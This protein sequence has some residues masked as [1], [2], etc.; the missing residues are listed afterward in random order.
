M[1]KIG[2][3]I[4]YFF[5]FILMSI[6]VYFIQQGLLI[7]LL[8][9]MF[10]DIIGLFSGEHIPD[11][12]LVHLPIEF[13]VISTFI[14]GL[15]AFIFGWIDRL[16]WIGAILIILLVGFNLTLAFFYMGMTPFDIGLLLL[17]FVVIT[18]T[19]PL[20]II[21]IH[22]K[23]EPLV[24][25]ATTSEA[26][27]RGSDLSEI[28]HLKITKDV[29]S[30][31]LKP[32]LI[33][34][35]AVAFV[36][37]VIASV[38]SEFVQRLLHKP[39]VTI[40]I[41]DNLRQKEFVNIRVKIVEEDDSHYL[42]NL[43]RMRIGNATGTLLYSKDEYL[44]SEVA[45]SDHYLIEL[46]LP[47]DDVKKIIN[48]R[49]PKETNTTQLELN[50][51]GNYKKDFIFNWPK[52]ELLNQIKI[53]KF[54]VQEKPF[55]KERRVLVDSDTNFKEGSFRLEKSTYFKKGYKLRN[56]NIDFR[57]EMDAFKIDSYFASESHV[58]YKTYYKNSIWFSEEDIK[59]SE[60]LTNFEKGILTLEADTYYG[61]DEL[62]HY[63]IEILDV[64]KKRLGKVS[65]NIRAVDGHINRHID[66]NN[67]AKKR[68][69]SMRDVDSYLYRIDTLSN[70]KKEEEK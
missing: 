11:D 19:L 25:N 49:L 17:A 29:A 55:K 43:H 4:P 44:F 24:A 58:V 66:I 6:F 50:N 47:D 28:K 56:I 45:R 26:Q 22:F 41:E 7:V 13:I 5:S 40:T 16:R 57:G 59:S 32:L 31:S 46:I 37:A 36:I 69:F 27:E 21:F 1:A 12:S 48:I 20:R 14:A 60:V 65:G 3:K 67:L 62:L 30:R 64:K 34:F 15:L 63:Y 54:M 18:V 2:E 53:E 10:K 61:A 38:N 70:F 39:K 68:G 42:N 52:T 33:G 51:Y 35:G 9:E 8:L 23:E